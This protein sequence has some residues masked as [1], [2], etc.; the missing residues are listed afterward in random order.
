MAYDVLEITRRIA[1]LGDEMSPDAIA[2]SQAIYAPLHER[3]PYAGVRVR[4]DAAYGAHERHR[5]DVF[6][7]ED[8]GA[9]EGGGRPVVVFVHGG[10][11]VRGDKHTPGTP[12]NDN[13]ALWAVRHGLVG[14]N[15]THRL[16]PEF[17]WPAGAEDVAAAL[18]WVR[19]HAGEHGGDGDRVYLMGTSAGATHAASY[20]AHR[21]F[22]PADGPGLAGVI[23]LSGVYDLTAFSAEER[24]VAYFGPDSEQYAERSAIQGLL[25]EQAPALFVI[26]EFDPPRFADQ[27]LRLINAYVKRHGRWPRFLRLLGHNHFTATL[28]LNTPDDSLGRHLLTFIEST[29]GVAQP[30][31]AP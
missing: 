9:P 27:A 19:A 3:E 17:P 30:A 22:Q 26:A 5:L 11:F 2:G 15:M 8:A 25:E 7:P 14:V 21:A 1:A 31:A 4:R 10:G 29:S 23:L 18:A 28:H 6:E 16:A 13:V 24:A 20:A 12:Y